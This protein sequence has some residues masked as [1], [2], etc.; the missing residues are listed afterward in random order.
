MLTT[1]ILKEYSSVTVEDEWSRAGPKLGRTIKAGNYHIQTGG[2]WPQSETVNS[3]EM[4]RS[5]VKWSPTLCD[6]MDCSLPGSSIH[7]ILQ[8]RVLEWVAISFSR[9]SSWPRDR[10]QVSCIAGRRFTLWATREARRWV[11]KRSSHSVEYYIAMIRKKTLTCNNMNIKNIKKS[12]TKYYILYD[13]IYV[14]F[15]KI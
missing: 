11:Q 10:T 9:G 3:T 6:P 7:G 15:Y 8:A 14:K 1:C 2:N 4:G 13:C 5:E 12:D